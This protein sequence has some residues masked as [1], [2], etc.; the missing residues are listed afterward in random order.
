MAASDL[1]DCRSSVGRPEHVRAALLPLQ[2]KYKLNVLAADPQPR[3]LMNLR[4]E[5]D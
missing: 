5:L 1:T 3:S 4:P 2:W